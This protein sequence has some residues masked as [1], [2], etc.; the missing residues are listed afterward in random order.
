MTC[1]SC[2]DK[3]VF[4]VCYHEGDPTDFAVCL[5]RAGEQF[6]VT[7]N[8][9]KAHVPHYQVWAIKHGIDL[10]RVAPM[11]VLFTDEELAERGFAEVSPAASIDAIAAAARNR[12]KR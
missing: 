1:Y 4:K 12:S 11:E 6:R 3:G 8:N 5:C 2:N 9:G 7:E 10:E